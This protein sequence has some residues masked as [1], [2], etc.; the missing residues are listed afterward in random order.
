MQKTIWAARAACLL[1]LAALTTLLLVPDPLAWLWGLAPDISPPSRGVHFT[2]FFILAALCAASRLPWK[3]T[4][5]GALLVVYALT[6]ESLQSLVDSRSVELI[7]YI[8]N[9][10]GLAVGAVAWKIGYRLVRRNRC[11]DQAPG[12]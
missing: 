4:T 12:D 1:Y 9:L 3:A 7:D 11:V 6:A 5:Q 8:E 2:A 10:L